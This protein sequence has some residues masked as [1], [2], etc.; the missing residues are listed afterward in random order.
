MM[1]F[2]LRL[3]L[4]LVLAGLLPLIPLVIS[5]R[6][7][8]ETGVSTLA[9]DET[10]SALQSGLELARGRLERQ[11]DQLERTVALLP[12]ALSTVQP[13]P[14]N[15]TVYLEAGGR[16]SRWTGN[17]WAPSN[18]PD[19]SAEPA[20]GSIPERLVAEHTDGR[21]RR[22]VIVHDVPAAFR[23]AA[24]LLQRANADWTVSRDQRA[25]L[26]DSLAGAYALTYLGAM[27]L[28]V[29]AALIVLTPLIRRI[30]RLTEVAESIRT[31]N[32]RI[33]AEETGGGETR[34]L[35]RTFNLMLDR[36]DNSRR[37]AAEME[38]R[39]AW[40]ELAP[41]LAHEIK[42]PLTPIQ[43]SVQQLADSYSGGDERFART[44]A[45]AREIVNEEVERLRALV[46]DFGDFARA[47]SP[48]PET[49]PLAEF[50]QDL[51]GLYGE[52]VEVSGPP[53]AVTA[54]FDRE[55]IR[56]ALVNLIENSLAATAGAGRVRVSCTLDE[57]QLRFVVEDDGP[58]IA[59]DKLD[60]IFEPYFTTKSNGIGLGL[61]VVRSTVE[62][63]GGSVAADRSRELGGA[64]FTLAL[65]VSAGGVEGG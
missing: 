20:F 46:R 59:D 28:A 44:L 21:G 10:G 61:P 11:R 38:K 2:R 14:D 13:L 56:R 52:R 17:G 1:T 6:H 33:R 55:K 48:E 50:M 42:N 23:D 24:R 3:I 4:A 49:V 12:V 51:A 57:G 34:R 43:L 37:H 26:I 16:W 60:M 8:I 7:A 15:E 25:R 29:I 35:A 41:V 47:P 18:E 64:R 9:P 53:D 32:E 19:L 36:L 31:G 27:A 63:H 45:D 39:A 54:F 58:G 62:Q 65:P 22:W 30:H 5:V 40:R